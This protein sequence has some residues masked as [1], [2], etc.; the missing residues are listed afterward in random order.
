MTKRVT[1]TISVSYKFAGDLLDEYLGWLDNYRDTKAMRRAFALDR[2]ISRQQ[3]AALDPKHKLVVR[4][5]D[6]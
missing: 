2:L 1:V 6:S 3:L 5:E 4:E